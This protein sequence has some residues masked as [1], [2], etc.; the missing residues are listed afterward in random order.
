MCKCASTTSLESLRTTSL[1]F[2]MELVLKAA[3]C[4]IWRRYFH[5]RTRTLAFVSA[6][7]RWSTTSIHKV[8]VME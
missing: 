1:V 4:R 2:P 5:D 6:W 3:D 7:A 8:M